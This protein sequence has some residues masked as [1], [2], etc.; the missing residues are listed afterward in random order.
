[1]SVDDSPFSDAVVDSVVTVHS[2]V[3]NSFNKSTL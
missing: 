1:M 3:K 2:S